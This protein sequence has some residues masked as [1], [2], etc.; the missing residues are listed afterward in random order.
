MTRKKI[1]SFLLS[2]AMLM[3]A[4]PIGVLAEEGENKTHRDV[5]LHALG[6]NPKETVDVSTVYIGETTELYFAVD[7]P[8]KGRYEKGKHLDPQYDMNGY[9]VKIYFDPAFF[10]YAQKN[11]SQPIDYRVPDTQIPESGTGSENIGDGEVSDTPLKIGYFPYKH[12]SGSAVINGKTYKTAYATIFFSGEFLPNKTWDGWYNICKLPLTPLKTGNTDVFIDVD[13]ADPYTLELFAKN[14]EDDPGEQTFTYSAR[15]GG[16]HHIIIKDKLKPTSPVATPNSGK[17]TEKQNVVLKTEEE[18]DIY[19]SIDGGKNFEPYTEPIEVER[20]MDIV[21]YGVRKS[22]GKPSNQVTFNYQIVPKAPVLYL[23]KDTKKAPN[24]Y[25]QNTAF[26]VY[27][28]HE[29]TFKNIDDDKNIYYTFND[30]ISEEDFTEGTNPADS[31]IPINK[32][33]QMLHIDKSVKVRLVT[34]NELTGE[35]SSVSVYYFGIKPAVVE[36]SHP[37]D[38]Y[39]EKIDVELST[40]TENAKILYTTDGSDPKT[41]GLEYTV[42]IP[43]G[44]DTPLRAVAFY[45][46]EYGDVSSFY[47]LF[48]YHDDYGVDAFYPSGVYDGS[49]NV[50]LT[51]S[52]PDYKVKYV[53]FDEDDDLEYEDDDLIYY[54]EVLVVDKNQ[55]IIAKAEDANG[56]L[57]ETEYTFTYKIKPLPPAFAPE[58]TQ[59]TNSD[60]VTI[61]S[62]ESNKDNT[63]RFELYYTTDGSDPVTSDTAK[64]ADNESDSAII[65]IMGYTVVSAV[66][67][68]DGES[69]SNVVTHSYDIVTKKPTRPITTL[70]PGN[71]IIPVGSDQRYTTL[72][73]PVPEGTKIYYRVSYD[74][75]FCPDPVPGDTENTIEY[76]GKPI[77]INGKTLIK[78]VAV[79]VFGVSG[80]VG[81]FDYTVTPEAP[82]AA[83]SSTINSEKLPVVPVFCVEGSTVKYEVN[84]KE[85]EFVA[86]DSIFYIDM[87]TGNAYSDKECNENDLLGDD[88]GEIIED[89]AILDIS[90]ELDG[91]ESESNRYTYKTTDDAIL[92]PPYP[93]KGTGT[94]EEIDADG[95]NNYILINLYSLNNGDTIEYRLDNEGSWIEYEGD[96]VPLKGDTVLQLRSVKDGKTSNVTSYIYNFVPLAPVITLPSGRYSDNPVPITELKLDSRAPTDARYDIWYRENGDKQDFRYTGG[97]KEIDH[98]MSF[99]AYV[100]NRD[101][102]KVSANTIHYYIIEPENAATGSV[103]IANPYDTDRISADVLTQRPYSDGIKL[104][105]QNKDAEIHYFYSYNRTDGTGATTN[106]FMYDNA[107]PIIVNALMDD[108]T[109]T[110]WLEQD[111]TKIEDSERRFHIDFVHLEVPETSLEDA[112]KTK[113]DKG[114]KYTIIDDYPDDDTIILWYT[115]DNSDPTD[116]DNKNRLLYEGE[117]LKLS[118]DTTV[119]TAYLSAC[120]KCGE[121]KNDNYAG[122]T[123]P[124]YSEVG[125]YKYTIPEKR[126][127]GGGGGGGVIDN[128]RKYTVDMFGYEHPTHIGYI[129]GYTDGSVR[130][131]GDITR[132]EMAAILYRVKKRAYDVPFT[133]TGTVFPD[134]PMEKWS[135]M[136][137]EFMT[138]DGV[139]FGYPD[140]TFGPENKLTRAEFASLIYRF[141]N[142]E[143]KGEESV[144]T[145]VTDKHWAHDYILALHET[146]LVAGYGDG[147]FGPD[148]NITRAEVMTVMNKILGRKP[149]PSY[150]K[151][152][153]Y[154]PFNDLDSDK[155]YFV[156]VMEATITHDYYFNGSQNYEIKWEDVK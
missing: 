41:N 122:C 129:M 5:F 109:I 26:D 118:E 95:D 147:T 20:T 59:F 99:K 110:A 6:K 62:P 135:V 17:Y 142:L 101:T 107:A 8:N 43:L 22:D 66:V 25:S 146:G 117:E 57:G 113:F 132:E 68:K 13:G 148:N 85:N 19:Y 124:V 78:A 87:S 15:N 133:V 34:R 27:A 100:K 51:P 11:T 69:Y 48:T 14:V 18:C 106:N 125:K 77:P 12:G 45:D 150:V 98:T 82:V 134:V 31:W 55:I 111:G 112:G 4:F 93:D 144:F 153:D 2:I 121:C 102:G 145:D 36:S 16:Y 86:K 143:Y 54:E 97:E 90:A 136:E 115:L 88:I 126:S 120:N 83:P 21:A 28:S 155:W 60:K 38:V 130:P 56:K 89:S 92:A 49:V 94:Y 103:Y 139:I 123:S 105:S 65:D 73:M 42:P 137:I 131:T 33:T 7:N 128:T 23:D 84:G 37:S 154:V 96:S 3:S 70:V 91:V 127:S 32:G 53:V 80:D 141:V 29:D 46:G 67:L 35:V 79:N 74:G 47:Y 50:T 114:T 76:T 108:I 72:F 140:G 1:L 138:D 9:T 149:F 61:Y 40:D 119:K 81:I 63:K 64:R 152:L 156:D 24:V 44:K 30:T 10:D 104:L 58:T 52:N 71:Y 75:D 116:P 151:S 39:D